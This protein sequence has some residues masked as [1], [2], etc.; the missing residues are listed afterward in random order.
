VF[1]ILVISQDPDASEIWFKEI[2]RMREASASSEDVWET[3]IQ[4]DA[5]NQLPDDFDLIFIDAYCGRDP[6]NR[7]AQDLLKLC[8]RL[9]SLTRKVILLHSPV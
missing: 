8:L 4:S 2:D 1:R 3:V 7:R 6:D 5:L 9:R